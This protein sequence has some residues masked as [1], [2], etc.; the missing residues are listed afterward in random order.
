[1]RRLRF[2]SFIA[3][4]NMNA[5]SC[6]SSSPVMS[7]LL[8]N[9]WR[10]NTKGNCDRLSTTHSESSTHPTNH[11]CCG[12][13]I[14]IWANENVP[15]EP[16]VQNRFAAEGKLA[17]DIFYPLYVLQLDGKKLYS[18][19]HWNQSGKPVYGAVELGRRTSDS[20][21]WD[22]SIL[23]CRGRLSILVQANYWKAIPCIRDESL[24]ASP[25]SAAGA[26]TVGLEDS[27]RAR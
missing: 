3:L 8:L 21:I 9:T 16:A 12:R 27:Y 15:A 17:N 7:N 22:T 4:T 14:Q 6:A 11:L 26:L 23:C 13:S 20:S 10:L 18:R 1:M 19:M 5:A 24:D 25:L 2:S